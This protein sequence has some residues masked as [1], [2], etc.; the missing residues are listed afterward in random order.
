M[1]A[2]CGSVDARRGE[3]RGARGAAQPCRSVQLGAR[4]GEA[5][6]QLNA[7]LWPELPCC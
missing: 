1:H 2:A 3:C 5:Q 4:L 7:R 6:E